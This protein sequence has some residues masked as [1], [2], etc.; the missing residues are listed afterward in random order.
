MTLVRVPGL[1]G[2]ATRSARVSENGLGVALPS[3]TEFYRVFFFG[4]CRRLLLAEGSARAAGRY[5]AEATPASDI[6]RRRDAADDDAGVASPP[7]AIDPGHCVG[8]AD[9]TFFRF[10]RIQTRFF[11]GFFFVDS[12]IQQLEDRANPIGSNPNPLRQG[13]RDNKGRETSR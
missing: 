1:A 3:F 7:T 11:L 9:L 5:D 8:V 6:D 2:G 10:S 4:G 12:E 13:E